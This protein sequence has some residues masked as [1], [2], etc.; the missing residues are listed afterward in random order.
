MDLLRQTQKLGLLLGDTPDVLRCNTA[1][2][3]TVGG[4]T[5]S[6]HIPYADCIPC[7]LLSGLPVEYCMVR[8][9]Y[10]V[11]NKLF[12]HYIR[13][14]LGKKHALGHDILCRGL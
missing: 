14:S 2:E 1:A 4:D 11:S 13:N 7:A 9:V 8:G 6:D 3:P 10:S 12:S 5:C